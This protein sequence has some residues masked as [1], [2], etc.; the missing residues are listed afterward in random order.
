[1]EP[2]PAIPPSTEELQAY[3]LGKCEPQRAAEIEAHLTAEPDQGAI[4]AAAPDDA[5]VRHLRGVGEL[6]AV[7]QQ[8]TDAGPLIEHPRYRF[9]RPLGQGGMGTVY[10]AEHRLLRRLVAIKRIHPGSLGN[11]HLVA[12]FRQEVQ[13]AARLSHPNIVTVH[14]ADEAGGTHLLVM[15]FV[16]G[17]SLAERLARHGPLPVAEACAYVRQAALGLAHAHEQGMV[18]RDV[19]PANLMHT[20]DGTVKILDFGLARVFCEAAEVEGRL[21]SAGTIMGTADYL[22]PEQARDSRSA[23]IRADVYSLGCTLYHLLCGHVPFPGG[24]AIDKIIQHATAEPEPLRRS[25]ADVSAGLA[26]VIDRM[27]AKRPAD[28]YQTPAEV[29][30]ALEPFTSPRRGGSSAANAQSSPRRSLFRS[31][32]RGWLLAGVLAGILLAVGGVVLVA[33]HDEPPAG[34]MAED[35]DK[36]PAPPKIELVRRIALLPAAGDFYYDS[37]ISQGGK[38]AVVTRDLGPGIRFDVYRVASGE[39]LWSG[40]GWRARFLGDGEQLIAVNA[41]RFVVRESR[42][43]KPLRQ[44]EEPCRG[45][46]DYKVGPGARHLVYS[47]DQGYALY[48]LAQLRQQHYWPYKT[49]GPRWRDGYFTADGKRLLLSLGKS[50]DWTVWDV[51]HNR[52]TADFPG[53][54]AD[55]TEIRWLYADGRTASVVRHGATVRLDMRTGKV[56]EALQGCWAP[57]AVASVYSSRGRCYAAR[58]EDGTFLLYRL[59]FEG[60]EWCRYQLP[61]DDRSLSR[62]PYMGARLALAEDDRHAALLTTRSLYVLRLPEVP[63]AKAD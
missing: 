16:E 20:V 36:A 55:V 49:A 46:G 12:R 63:A 11:P 41:E 31:R 25:R 44:S 52:A 39:K 40:D 27:M 4:L 22:A 3:S 56:V 29:A 23:D 59:P 1:M 8:R 5:L 50:D 7:E 53:L 43:G 60:K 35:E 19:K 57:G 45:A 6:H 58:C 48:D 18:H 33:R 21:T 37:H 13:A 34:P 47:N 28:R 32:P 38:Y 15:E 24:T 30:A 62:H 9:L 10:L 17:E 26:Q 61:E 14:D 54:R 51:E 42:S 2:R